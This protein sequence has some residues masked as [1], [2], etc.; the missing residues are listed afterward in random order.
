VWTVR[1]FQVRPLIFG[2]RQDN[3]LRFVSESDQPMVL[4][5]SPPAA[6]VVMAHKSNLDGQP[7][8]WK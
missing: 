2:A 6:D 4:R 7:S 1:G 5:A 8:I 3:L